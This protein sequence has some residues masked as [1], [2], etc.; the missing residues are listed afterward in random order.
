MIRITNHQEIT[1]FMM[2]PQ[3]KESVNNQGFIEENQVTY[4][5]YLI[6]CNDK[7]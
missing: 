3:T 2:T 5:I 6:D 7:F 4:L 1:M